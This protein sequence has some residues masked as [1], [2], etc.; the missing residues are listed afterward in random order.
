MFFPVVL[1]LFTVGGCC[2]LCEKWDCNY[3]K[4]LLVGREGMSLLFMYV[5]QSDR[6]R[7]SFFLLLRETFERERERE[8]KREW[9]RVW[10]LRFC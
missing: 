5:G 7:N 4:K 8:R 3:K 9:R 10:R 2:D 1:L 6:E